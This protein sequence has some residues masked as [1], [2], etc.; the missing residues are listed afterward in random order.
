MLQSETGTSRVEMTRRWG[1][2]TRL[3]L[4]IPLWQ[5]LDGV[6]RLG[7]GDGL[8]LDLRQRHLL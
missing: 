1:G 6:E 8:I 4:P 2:R 5:D 3:L 7:G